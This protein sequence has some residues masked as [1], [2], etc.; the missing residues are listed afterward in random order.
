VAP[1]ADTTTC[2][3]QSR[4][5]GVKRP[6]AGA[7]EAADPGA[8]PRPS[9]ARRL[10]E[11]QPEAAGRASGPA[12]LAA[13]EEEAGAEE[14]APPARLPP[15]ARVVAAPG[16]APGQQPVAAAISSVGPQPQDALRHPRALRQPPCLARSRPPGRV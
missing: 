8:G 6:A 14:V 9:K 4:A 11:P 10:L 15:A 1:E 12:A 16:P 2:G 13:E 5:P 3:Q 7:P